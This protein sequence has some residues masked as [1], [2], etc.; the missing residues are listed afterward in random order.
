[1]TTPAGTVVLQVVPDAG[2][3]RGAAWVPFNLVTTDLLPRRLQHLLGIRDLNPA[4]LATVRA[5]QVWVRNSVAHL[6]G[7][8]TDN[9][10][11]GRVLRSSRAVVAA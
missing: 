8:W 6:A 1:M 10:L 4:E 2:V 5:T 3:G 11:S 7:A 9:P